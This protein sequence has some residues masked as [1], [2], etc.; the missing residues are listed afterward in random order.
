[1]TALFATGQ[2]IGPV[3]AGFVYDLTG[4]FAVSLVVASA[5]LPDVRKIHERFEFAPD[6]MFMVLT[7]RGKTT[8]KG[9]GL[10]TIRIGFKDAGTEGSLMRGRSISVD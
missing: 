8:G 1:M 10:L 6:D 3:F 7:V 5:V 4:S 2:M 9:K